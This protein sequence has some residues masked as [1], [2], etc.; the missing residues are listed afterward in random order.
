M[1]K[2]GGDGATGRFESRHRQ[3]TLVIGLNPWPV[4]IQTVLLDQA[5][6]RALR[7]GLCHKGTTIVHATGPSDEA[8]PRPHPAA[9]RPQRLHATAVEPVLDV[10]GALEGL[11]QNDSGSA[12]VTTKGLT[13]I[14]GCTPIMRR[15]C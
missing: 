6:L 2:R 12:W 7:Q 3:N 10:L 15:V 5:G 8:I 9:V 13:A 11:H 1:V 14:L 4:R